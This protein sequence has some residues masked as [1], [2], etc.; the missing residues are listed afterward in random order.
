MNIKIAGLCLFA[1]LFVATPVDAQ[2]SLQ[3]RGS[4]AEF[5]RSDLVELLARYEEAIQ[6]PAYSDDVRETARVGAERIRQ[7]LERGD[8]RLGDRIALNVRGEPELPDTVA[9]QTGPLITLPLFGEI[10]LYGVLRSE[11]EDHLTAE[12]GRFIN[13]PVVEAKALTRLSVQG[14]VLRP[15]FYVV[16]ADML[17]SE[18]LMLAGGPAPTA[19]VDKL[20][21]QRANEEL[22]KEDEVQA[23]L[24]QGLTLDQL[25]LQAGDEL[26][27]PRAS[28]GGVWGTVRDVALIVVPLVGTIAL[29]LGS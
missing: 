11:L 5:S 27:L 13:E 1:L 24:V 19:D 3:V 17:L 14:D 20:R 21:V 8:F 6:S 28:A 25:S 9:V 18:A 4:G 7:R 22:L 10:D 23:A 2:I 15:G 16:P 29:L 12:L 26:V